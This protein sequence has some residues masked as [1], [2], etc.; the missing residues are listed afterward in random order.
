[1]PIKAVLFDLDNTLID[2]M[3]LKRMCVENAVDAMI[4]AGLEMS[5][6]EATK[7]MLDIYFDLGVEYQRIF[8]K[9]SNKVLGCEDYKIMSAGIVAYRKT[10]IAYL[11]PYPHVLQTLTELFRRGIKLGVITDAGRMQAWI[12][13]SALKLNHLFDVVVTFDDTGKRKP[14]E[15]PFRKALDE[16]DI[17]PEE[18]LFVGDW[19]ERDILGAKNVGMRTCLARYGT[20]EEAGDVK[21]D[22]EVNDIKEILE[23]VR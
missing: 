22:Y 5:K 2:F 23:L 9:F 8:Q 1:M 7:I 20:G 3:K 13:I 11:E 18:C 19:I 6:E 15:E 10:K 16:L 12:R 4:D 17:K 21:A 14:D